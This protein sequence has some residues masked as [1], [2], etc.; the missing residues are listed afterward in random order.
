VTSDPVVQWALTGVF[1]ALSGHS[2]W[3]LVAARQILV[4]MG[5]L[6][7]LGMNLTMVVMVWPWWDRLPALP[8]LA[9]FVVAAVFFAAA[10]GWHA[11]DVLPRGPALDSRRAACHRRVRTLAVHAVMMLAMVWAV[12]AMSPALLSPGASQASSGLGHAR[13]TDHVAEHAEL[14]TWATASG[15]LLAALL[16]V[17]G[18]YFLVRLVRHLRRGGAV[19]GRAGSD[20]LASAVMS[21]GMAAMCGLMMTG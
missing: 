16:V 9:F 20:L 4:A 6:F 15:S 3:R 19:R 11:V 12:A 7:H 17:G 14:G 8:Q 18:I 5:H 10:A 13:H 1:A 2:L 21:F